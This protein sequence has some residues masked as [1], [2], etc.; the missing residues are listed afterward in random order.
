M[1]LQQHGRGVVGAIVLVMTMSWTL[2]TSGTAIAG[3][4]PEAAL[5]PPD[6][7]GTHFCYYEGEDFAGR[8]RSIGG[9][10]CVP[11]SWSARSYI[12]NTSAQGYFRSNYDCSGT[13]RAVTPHTSGNIGFA[14]NSFQ[15]ACVTCRSEG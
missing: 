1:V 11:L 12:N 6:C 10:G 7:G 9:D 2:A 15:F 8:S 5:Q 3:N 14:A 13:T 4:A